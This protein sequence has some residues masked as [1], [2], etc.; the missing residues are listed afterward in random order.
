MSEWVAQRFLSPGDVTAGVAPLGNA[1]WP[2][3]ARGGPGKETEA[4]SVSMRERLV[5]LDRGLP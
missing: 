3:A 4:V 5:F 1:K 2:A